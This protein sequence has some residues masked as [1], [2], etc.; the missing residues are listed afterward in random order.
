MIWTVLLVGAFAGLGRARRDEPGPRRHAP[1]QVGR[2]PGE[3]RTVLTALGP[4][5]LAGE[6]WLVAGGGRPARRVPR[7][8]S[9]TSGSSRT[10]WS[11]R[12]W[13]PGC[14]ATPGSG[15]AAGGPASRW[16]AGW[17]RVIVVASVGL[18][19]S[20]GALL[21][22]ALVWLPAAAV[23]DRAGGRTGPDRPVR[24]RRRPASS[25]PRS[26]PPGPRA[27]CASGP[28]GWPARALPWSAGLL[29][30]VRDRVRRP[31]PRRRSAHAP[32]CRRSSCSPGPGP[33]SWRDR[34]SL[35]VGCTGRS[36]RWSSAA[37]CR[38]S[39][40]AIGPRSPR[41]SPAP[42]LELVLLACVPVLLAAQA[43]VWWTFRHPVSPRDAVFYYDPPASVA[44]EHAMS[45]ATGRRR[46]TRG[47]LARRPPTLD[48]VSSLDDP[49]P[50][51]PPR[52]TAVLV[53]VPEAEPVVARHRATL[54]AAAGWGIP[55]HVTVLFPFA[56]PDQLD[57]AL[58][59]ALA[60]RS[61]A[62]PR[63]ACVFRRTG[64]VR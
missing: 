59:G 21:G 42:T 45:D 11:S 62:C 64:M 32:S 55:A 47:V 56:P 50:T 19:L 49:T 63:S 27:S 23:A 16:R 31:R 57:A 22:A 1:R 43:W 36:P 7:R 10:R 25:A 17:E 2:T 14:S 13:S 40:A 28:P 24:R 53:P 3:R 30:G 38:S 54:D 5:L 44:G 15:C 41:A 33:R 46:G 18:P 52:W 37:C 12:C 60:R 34:R 35:T 8:W 51:V 29:A 58:I 39:R 9:A 4:F 61:R 26:S 6:V 20:A 48:T